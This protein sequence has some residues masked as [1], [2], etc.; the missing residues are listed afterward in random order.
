MNSYSFSDVAVQDLDEIC[1]YVAQRDPAAAS[2]LFDNI[3]KR[4][5][6]LADFPN[7]GKSYSQLSPDLRGA[8][9]EEYIILYYPRTDGIDVARVVSGYRDLE[10][11][12]SS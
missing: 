10:V 8:I 3:R 5:K 7:S 12:F 9:V 4:C 6:L 1:D 2:K 11:L